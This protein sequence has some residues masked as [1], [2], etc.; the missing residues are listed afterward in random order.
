MIDFWRWAAPRWST[1]GDS[2]FGC[3]L[4]VVCGLQE[5]QEV[6]AGMW[7]NWYHVCDRCSSTNSGLGKTSAFHATET[8]RQIFRQP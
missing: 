7:L 4:C 5:M 3:I 6:M 1:T 2:R 8:C